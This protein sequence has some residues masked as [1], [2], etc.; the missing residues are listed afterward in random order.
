MNTSAF[1]KAIR[2]LKSNIFDPG[3]TKILFGSTT[4][5]LGCLW[6]AEMYSL[7]SISP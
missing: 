4:K 3:A 1:L 5:P 6:K 7:S 2:I